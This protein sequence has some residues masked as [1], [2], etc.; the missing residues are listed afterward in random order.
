MES[1]RFFFSWLT[2]FSLQLSRDPNWL[3]LSVAQVKLGDLG[4]AQCSVDRERDLVAWQTKSRK[5][6][7]THYVWKSME[8]TSWK[9]KME[10]PKWR[11]VSDH[12][13]FQRGW[14]SGS[15]GEYKQ[16]GM[17][18][19]RVDVFWANF[20]WEHHG[21]W[22]CK[23]FGLFV[24]PTSIRFICIY[25]FSK[26]KESISGKLFILRNIIIHHISSHCTIFS[27]NCNPTSIHQVRNS[28]LIRSGASA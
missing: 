24:P 25:Y 15:M 10:H 20:L 28:R 1:R 7:R 4:L 9:I 2:S 13:P 19:G 17:G 18:K 22:G 12:F 5:K 16:G 11:F 27:A 26:G 21:I 3:V 8:H 23:M 14:F 6:R